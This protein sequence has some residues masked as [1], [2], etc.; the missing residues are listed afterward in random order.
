MPSCISIFR[1]FSLFFTLCADGKDSNCN[2]VIDDCEEDQV[3]PTIDT[4]T[5]VDACSDLWFNSAAEAER[6]V[7]DVAQITDDCYVS[8]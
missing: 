6:C 1:V 8:G 5:I 4:A 3:A 2:D 7:R